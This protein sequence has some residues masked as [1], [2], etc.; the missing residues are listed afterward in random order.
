[1]AMEQGKPDAVIGAKSG[2]MR[3]VAPGSRLS[4]APARPDRENMRIFAAMENLPQL[5]K[6]MNRVKKQLGIIDEPKKRAG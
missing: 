3:E 2:I 5:L 6:D 1:M 4:G